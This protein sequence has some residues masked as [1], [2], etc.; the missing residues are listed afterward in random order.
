MKLLNLNKRQTIALVGGVYGGLAIILLGIYGIHTYEQRRVS[1]EVGNGSIYT[2]PQARDH[3][4][5][6]NNNATTTI[7]NYFSMDCSH[8]RELFLKE[9]VL[10]RENPVLASKINLIYRHNPL[11]S[12]P[13]SQE[14]ALIGE[15][16]YQQTDDTTFF[17]FIRSVFERYN[18]DEQNN[19]W[20]KKIAYTFIPSQSSFD[21]CL[22]DSQIQDALQKQK[23][24]SLLSAIIYT[25]TLLVYS[26]NIFVRKYDNI[27]GTAAFEI[28]KYYLSH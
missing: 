5:L 8:C 17:A 21:K 16:V 22:S 28:T 18:E 27:G 26:N 10:L 12:Q 2:A 23:N 1:S 24:D 25:P 7:V 14:K 4:K 9:D 3:Y 6:K 20:V 15:C 13:L 11:A 19:L